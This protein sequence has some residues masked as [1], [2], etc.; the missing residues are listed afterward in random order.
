MCNEIHQYVEA[1]IELQLFQI[2]IKDNKGPW[3]PPFNI[4][5]QALS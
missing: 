1:D 3:L 5:A 4:E 2:L